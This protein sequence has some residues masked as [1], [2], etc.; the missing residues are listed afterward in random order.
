VANI[1]SIAHRRYLRKEA[2]EWETTKESI[3]LSLGCLQGGEVTAPA[4]PLVGHD[5][6]TTSTSP[7]RN[8][9]FRF[10]GSEFEV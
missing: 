2:F 10:W 4:D 3:L 6:S 7:S 8:P 5:S 1:K 9:T